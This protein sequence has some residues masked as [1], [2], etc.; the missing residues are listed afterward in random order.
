MPSDYGLRFHDCQNIR[1]SRPEISQGGPK[2]TIQTG[3]YRARAFAFENSYLLPQLEDFQRIIHAAAE[4]D[5][6]GCEECCEQIDHTS[7]HL[8]LCDASRGE[9]VARNGKLLI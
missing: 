7:T 1:P 4:E 2:E 3:E 9:S 6:D 5:T 8:I